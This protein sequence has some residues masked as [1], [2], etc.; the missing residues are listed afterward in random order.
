MSTRSN[1]PRWSET[2]ALFGGRFDPPHLGHAEAIRGL[3]E[4]PGIR[5]LW[6]IPSP[7][8][9]HKSAVAPF[10]HRVELAKLALLRAHPSRD[11]NAIRIDLREADRARLRPD[12]PTYSFDTIQDIRRENSKIAFVIGT[13]Q[14]EQLPSWHRFPEVL[15]LCH[16]IVLGRKPDGVARAQKVLSEWE[17]SGLVQKTLQSGTA[18][19]LW[20]IKGT[21]S[22]LNLVPTEAAQ[23]SSTEIR[24]QIARTGEPPQDSLSAEV[25]AYLKQNRL[26]GIRSDSGL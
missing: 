19:G 16:W 6:V 18:G 2:T 20:W 8:P 13:D 22:Y 26:Y 15:S 24:E 3:F 10:E 1:P 11:A 21:S 14:L 23:I 7:T 12:L 17:S 4:Q 25:L 9:P 5:E